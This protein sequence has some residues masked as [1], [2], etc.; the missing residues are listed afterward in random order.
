MRKPDVI[1]DFPCLRIHFVVINHAVFLGKPVRKYVAGNIQVHKVVQLLVYDAD[2]KLCRHDRICNVRLFTIDKYFARVR[3]L[4][5]GQYLH[6][7]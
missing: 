2:A 3:T 1:E 7:R 4:R 5:A 6:Q